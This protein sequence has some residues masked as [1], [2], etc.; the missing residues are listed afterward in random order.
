LLIDS[1]HAENKVPE[2]FKHRLSTLLENGIIERV[3][4]GKFILS[5]HFYKFLGKKGVYT[6]KKGLDKETNK[7]LLLK[8]IKDNA[9][10]GT[11]LQEL[12]QVLPNH[13]ISQVQS[14][15]R[16]LRNEEKV[17]CKGKTRGGLWYPLDG[18]IA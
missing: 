7:T 11:R 5:K 18:F 1:V 9:K 3:G 14:L 2:D 16:E 13:S 10:E 8:H 15:L 17:F 6:R 12:L 4:K